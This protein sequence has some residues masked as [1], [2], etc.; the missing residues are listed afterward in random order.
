[1]AK[2]ASPGNLKDVDLFV[3]EQKANDFSNATITRHQTV[4]GDHGRIETRDITVIHNIGLLQER[5]N[6]PAIAGVVMVESTRVIPGPTRDGDKVSVKPAS[7]LR[8]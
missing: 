4:D 3:A 7:T 6:W 8:H 2:A 1:L 5:H